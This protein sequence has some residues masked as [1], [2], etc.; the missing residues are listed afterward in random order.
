MI[1]NRINKNFFCLIKAQL[2]WLLKGLVQ[3]YGNLDF[4]KCS[5]YSEITHKKFV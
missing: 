2:G 3:A 5:A 1:K 4:G